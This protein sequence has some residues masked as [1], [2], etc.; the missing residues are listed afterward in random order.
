MLGTTFEC[1]SSY[2][3]GQ[4]ER[5]WSVKQSQGSIVRVPSR[6]PIVLGVDEQRNSTNFLRNADAAIGCAKKQ[7]AAQA[8]SLD[9]SVFG[10]TPQRAIHL[11][12]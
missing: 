7:S 8:A 3:E 6:H 2:R 12:R 5:Q 11:T 1:I 4:N 10:Q 9:A